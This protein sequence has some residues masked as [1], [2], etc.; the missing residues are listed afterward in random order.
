[1]VEQAY[2]EDLKSSARRACGFESRSEHHENK[3]KLGLKI[4]CPK[5][6]AGSNPAPAP[7]YTIRKSRKASKALRGFTFPGIVCLA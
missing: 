6:L 4:S 3:E 7:N 2:T 1:M 5:G